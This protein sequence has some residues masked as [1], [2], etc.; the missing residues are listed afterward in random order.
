VVISGD[1]LAHFA[2]FF[3]QDVTFAGAGTLRL[4]Q[5]LVYD[6][7][8]LTKFYSGTISG[9][10]AG[11]T[12]DLKALNYSCTMT[13][14]WNSASHTLEM[15]RAAALPSSSFRNAAES[16]EPGIHTHGSRLWIPGSSLRSAPE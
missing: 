2:D 15:R 14:V 1:G 13:D 5:S 9:F 7:N 3:I 6:D 4:D 10:G 11:D 8:A 12:I 16:R